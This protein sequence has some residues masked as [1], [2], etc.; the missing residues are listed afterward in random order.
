M[1]DSL[2]QHHLLI[3]LEYSKLTEVFYPTSYTMGTGSP[4]P[5]VKRPG[6]EADHSPPTSVEVKRMWIYTSTPP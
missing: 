2:I 3:V 4:F 5:G 6:R 1:K